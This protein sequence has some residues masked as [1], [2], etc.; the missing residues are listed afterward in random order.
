MTY[1]IQLLF[2]TNYG[3]P[4]IPSQIICLTP[5]LNR[6]YKFFALQNF[7][8][9]LSVTIC[10]FFALCNAELNHS[11]KAISTQRPKLLLGKNKQ[12]KIPPKSLICKLI[13]LFAVSYSQLT[14]LQVKLIMT[15]SSL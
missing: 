6:S 2:F 8:Q 4:A 13:S 15:E 10:Y 7:P 1:I 14:S 5:Q 3:L 9:I 12:T 11:M